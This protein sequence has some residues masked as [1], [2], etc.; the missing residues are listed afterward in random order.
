MFLMRTWYF[1][2]QIAIGEVDLSGLQEMHENNILFN[3]DS[4][5]PGT[6]LPE[7][8]P[9]TPQLS[10]SSDLEAPDP[11]LLMDQEDVDQEAAP[12][13]EDVNGGPIDP[14][15]FKLHADDEAVQQLGNFR[16]EEIRIANEFINL[17]KKAS[18]DDEFNGLDTHFTERLRHPH[19]EIFTINDPD[20]CLSIDTYLA[21]GNVSQESYH[22]VQNG[23][24]W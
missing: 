12:I 13:E 22:Q 10:E 4:D 23:I 18:L 2:S 6:S 7:S 8:V 15:R 19:Q 21:T 16:I 1:S 9:T 11:G 17:L 20:L 24:L 14:E 5:S 3:S